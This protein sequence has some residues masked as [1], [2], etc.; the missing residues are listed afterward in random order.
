MIHLIFTV[1]DSK[2]ELYLQPFCD[3]TK[4]QAI[5]A[6]TDAA[7]EENHRFCKYA[8]DFTLFELGEYEDTNGQFKIHKSKIPLG[9]AIE[10]KESKT[11]IYADISDAKP[12]LV[13]R[14]N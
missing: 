13:Q 9:N 10:Y 3:Q 12:Q 14:E 6:F 4:G 7:N 2:A 8:E 1:Y 11:A 5:R